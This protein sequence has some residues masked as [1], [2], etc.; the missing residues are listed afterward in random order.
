MLF[1]CVTHDF[2]GPVFHVGDVMNVR[3]RG[4]FMRD[5]AHKS[6]DA[7]KMSTFCASIA[8]IQANLTILYYR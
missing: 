8:A 2:L 7:R 3:R 1:W 5:A 6:S 4:V